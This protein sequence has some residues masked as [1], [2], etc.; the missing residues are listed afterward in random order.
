M[1]VF[2]SYRYSVEGLLK[3]LQADIERCKEEA[4]DLEI[5]LIPQI[6]AEIKIDKVQAEKNTQLALK[7]KREGYSQDSLFWYS[8]VERQEKYITRCNEEVKSF[9]KSIHI[10]EE[11][12]CL[13]NQVSSL[14]E[15]LKDT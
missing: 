13:I 2:S 8:C 14:L 11:C 5:N 15:G 6:E 4:N 9:K 12:K 10:F 7:T 3:E 1:P